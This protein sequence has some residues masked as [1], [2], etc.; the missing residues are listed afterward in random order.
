[1][2]ERV[3]HEGGVKADGRITRECLTD[4]SGASIRE[5]WQN[6]KY[7]TVIYLPENS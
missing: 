6:V 7:L 1:M 5:R 3:I 4:V 2:D